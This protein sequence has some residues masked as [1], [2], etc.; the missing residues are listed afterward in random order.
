LAASSGNVIA[1]QKKK[2]AEA[3]MNQKEIREAQALADE[4]LVQ[5]K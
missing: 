4:W 3:M 2:A 1:S 5:H